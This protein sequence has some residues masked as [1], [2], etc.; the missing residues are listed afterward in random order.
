M[1]DSPV[2]KSNE[3]YIFDS[4]NIEL[5]IIGSFELASQRKKVAEVED[6]SRTRVVGL[7]ATDSSPLLSSLRETLSTPPTKGED[8]RRIPSQPSSHGPP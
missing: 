8:S 4:D 5:Y 6:A 3:Q 2:K 7:K 1:S